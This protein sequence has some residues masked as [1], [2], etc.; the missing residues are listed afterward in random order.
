MYIQLNESK[1]RPF[2]FGPVG[3]TLLVAV[4][5]VGIVISTA[6]GDPRELIRI[7]TKYSDNDPLGTEGY[8][9]QFVYYIARDLTPSEVKSHLDVSPYRYQRILLPLLAR[10]LSF[11]FKPVLP[12]SLAVIGIISHAIG[13]SLVMTI[14]Q[15]WNV[16]RWYAL[17]YGLWVGLLLGIRLG[18]PEPLAYALVTGAL[19]ANWRGHH[20]WSWVLYT[21]ALFAKEVVILFVAAQLLSDLFNRRWTNVIGLSLVTLLPYILFQGWL[22]LIFGYPGIGSG[23]EM[24]TPFEFIPFMGL[25]RIGAFSLLLFA[26]YTLV[27]GPFV[28]YPGLWGIWEGV[29]KWSNGN[30][31]IWTTALV[32]N[33]LVIPFLP[34]STFRE[35]GGLLRFA[36]GL[37]L[38]VLLYACRYR[39]RRV[40]NYS[41]LWIVLNVFLFKG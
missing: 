14:L 13:T 30:K 36:S 31:E 19:L 6:S 41:F 17:I 10:I 12:W 38:A 26:A 11:G 21:F 35:P 9:G 20:G 29:K 15:S 33:G 37:V 22:W 16:S 2:L 8:D 40:M 25:F 28:I 5:Y 1:L 24:A 27:F 39:I 7:G 4:L 18:L 3:I 23:G 32:F 34:F